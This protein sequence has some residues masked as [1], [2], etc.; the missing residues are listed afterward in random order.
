MRK[1]G[2][3]C[4]FA[5]VAVLLLSAGSSYAK[6]T[7]ELSDKG[8]AASQQD[9]WSAGIVR[10]KKFVNS[11]DVS[12]AKKQAKQLK[13]QFPQNWTPDVQA[14]VDAEMLYCRNKITKAYRAYEKFITDY[15]RSP[16]Y[17]AVM[18][19]Q[20][21]VGRA[22][23]N[24]R[25][26]R[27]L[28]FFKLKGYEEGKKIM[29]KVGKR[30]GATPLGLRTMITVAESMERQQQYED[31]YLQWS[32]IHS[33]WPENQINERAMLSLGR[34]KHAAYKGP[35]FDASPL[36]SAKSFYQIYAEKYQS[37]AAEY[38]ILAR[39]DE[40]DEQ[41]AY[42]KYHI[43]EYYRRTGSTQAANM[44]YQMVIDKWP[45][46]QAA[47]MSAAAMAGQIEIK[48]KGWLGKA[49]EKLDK[50]FL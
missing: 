9:S 14:F 26:K 31:A 21:E 7:F 3:I 47:A 17:D 46:S 6:D 34:T 5:A 44:Y 37:G 22:Y 16:L 28:G 32:L 15:P 2:Y 29:E 41:T 33:Q 36:L 18:E 48:E 11:G 43:A 45:D 25:K 4:F 49:V 24:G 35:R 12:N 30:A 38:R 1:Y 13:S 39:I 20:Y 50:W 40:I 27:V 42:K 19:R 10:L 8:M 23:L